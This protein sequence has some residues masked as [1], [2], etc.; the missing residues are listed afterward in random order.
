M[1]KI[2]IKEFF[3]SSEK[4]AI[5]CDTEDKAIALCNAFHKQGYEC[6]SGNLREVKE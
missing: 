6:K 2:T 3:E 1:S 4:L 5:H